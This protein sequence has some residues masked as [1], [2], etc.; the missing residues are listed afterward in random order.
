MIYIDNYDVIKEVNPDIESFITQITRD[1]VGLGIYV[2]LTATRPGV[3]R[4]SIMNNFK[5][6]LSLYM[7]EKSDMNTVVGRTEYPIGEIKGRGL[8]KLENVNQVQMYVAT[9]FK[10]AMD[11]TD[12]I[13]DIV[14]KISSSYTGER[15]KSIP[16]LPE[17]LTIE[18]FKEFVEDTQ[19]KYMIPIG[20]DT[21]NVEVQYMDITKSRQIIVGGSQTGKTN[22][23]KVL[24][25]TVSTDVKVYLIDSMAAELVEYDAQENITYINNAEALINLQTDL[26]QMIMEREE[27]YEEEKEIVG[28]IVPRLFY[29]KLTPVLIVIEEFD[30]LVDM[31]K[32]DK[33][34]GLEGLLM[35]AELYNISIVATAS[36]MKGYDALSKYMKESISGIIL[37]FPGEQNI[38][39][40]PHMKQVNI[41]T[42]IGYIYNKGELIKIKTPMN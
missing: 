40:V 28:N 10:K 39:T 33:L 5:N 31:I 18:V 42:G 25:N 4:Y 2:V 22:L 1:G 30:T 12:S 26:E 11:Y 20:L 37:G 41:P 36:K 17:E 35:K 29:S 6:K 23:L 38:Y 32:T 16:M 19:D 14:N 34:T 15:A 13:G 3:V 8:V 21:E 9:T 7:F 27:M 24:L